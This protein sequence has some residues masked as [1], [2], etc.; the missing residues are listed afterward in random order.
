MRALVDVRYLEKNPDPAASLESNQ[1]GKL[2]LQITATEDACANHGI[3]PVW[4][5]FCLGGAY[6]ISGLSTLG[7]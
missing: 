3:N 6:G 7:I 2:Q 5:N 1:L 4:L